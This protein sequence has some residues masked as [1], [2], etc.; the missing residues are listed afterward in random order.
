M[1]QR[2]LAMLLAM[3]ML[4]SLIPAA[5]AAEESIPLDEAHFPDA[6]FRGIVAEQFDSNADG[7]LSPEEIDWA[8]NLDISNEDIHS[9]K[10]VEYLT[11]L[12]W[13]RLY[14]TGITEL[15][16]SKNNKIESLECSDNNLTEL[17]L[18]GLPKLY[19][20]TCSGNQLKKLNLRP[21]PGLVRLTCDDNRLTQ[22]DLSPVSY[23]QHL[24]CEKNQLTSLN[25]TPVPDMDSLFCNEN[26]LAD[27]DFS[28]CVKLRL[29]GCNGNR[30]TSLD[31]S[32]LPNLLALECSR[33]RLKVLD[34]S[35]NPKLE[36]LY[37]A[38]NLLT[39]LN[40]ENVES[41]EKLDCSGNRLEV[42]DVSGYDK[43]K[44]LHCGRN[45]LTG[46]KISEAAALEEF[47][48]AG[49]CYVIRNE[50]YLHELPGS[51]DASKIPLVRGGSLDHGY[52]YF[53]PGS[54]E[55][56]YTYEAGYDYRAE[57]RLLKDTPDIPVTAAK[58]PDPA[59]YSW[60][61]DH[62]DRDGN[63]KLSP[64]EIK[65]V[66]EMV[67][68][69][70]GIRDLTGLQYFT[71]LDV[72]DCS[73]NR[74]TNLDLSGQKYLTK[75]DCGDNRLPELEIAGLKD[76]TELDCRNNRL[77]V[78]DVSGFPRLASLNCSG[79]Y[80]CCLDIENNPELNNPTCFSNVCYITTETKLSQ[81]PGSPDPGRISFAIGGYLDNG[82]IFF[83]ATE[84]QINY[85]YLVCPKRIPGL[86]AWFTLTKLEFTEVPEQAPTCAEDGHKAH[87]RG[88]N[89]KFYQKIN[90]VMTEV[91][92]D[93]VII[94]AI[95]H[96]WQTPTYEWSKD[97]KECTATRVCSRDASHKETETVRSYKKEVLPTCT[98]QGRTV[99]TALFTA[100]WAE[101]QVK[102]VIV[103]AAGHDWQAPAYRWSED[104]TE[105]TATRVCSRDETHVETETVKSTKAEMA[106]GCT[107]EGKVTY[108]AVF[109]AQWAEDQTAEGKPLPALGHDWG[110]PTYRWNEKHTSCTATRVCRRD[111]SHVETAEGFITH[112]STPADISVEG[113]ITYIATFSVGWAEPQTQGP[114]V[115]PALEEADQHFIDISKDA[116]YY[117]AVSF[118]FYNGLFGGTGKN[119]FEPN[120]P[121]TRAMLVTVLWRLIGEEEELGKNTFED[122]P[123]DEWYTEAVAWAA[124][125]D[126]V[127]GV[128]NNC[129]APNDPITREQM[130]AILFR[131]TD[132]DT[133]ESDLSIFPDGD[134]VSDW[135]EEAM[136]WAVGGELINGADG[137]LQPQG[138]ATRAQV[139][140]ILMRFIYNFL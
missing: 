90:G 105:C 2:F 18:I 52:I 83:S 36:D 80:L 43:L 26:Q 51:P 108:K 6:V 69:D 74:L 109:E 17:N 78:L 23:L 29:I 16:V 139:A 53:D 10:G 110:E 35:S 11:E 42:L 111:S 134:K 93:D 61:C 120:T 45:Q 81:L 5:A 4:C 1:K 92:D 59:F 118:V 136:E 97:C 20:L 128:G 104:L 77:E 24:D 86:V 75:L 107:E 49:N 91:P 96:I 13:L 100:N 102:D 34:L 126:I 9:V 113:E 137:L 95:G 115:L 84:N 106:P 135:A 30:L 103:P 22:L 73:K 3:A 57:F 82:E 122:V 114:F 31:V 98:A 127:N 123:D 79:N 99:Y 132:W 37:C 63:G 28:P 25:L 87:Y 68:S 125:L 129:F 62:V 70:L 117:E 41:M 116:W 130:A 94:P 33:N 39:S 121:M 48:S 14:K 15:N 112:K 40:L 64:V 47:S 60:I 21:V 76:L 101:E 46:L 38:D 54:D 88:N 124:H 27:L 89:G 133:I 119:T 19:Q 72:L 32:M 66:Y 56:F 55:I 138:L 131:L 44:H 50:E 85:K 65:S 58:F 12:T 71:S 140:A 7:V 67:I 8:L